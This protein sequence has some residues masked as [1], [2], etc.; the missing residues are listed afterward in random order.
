MAII[1]KDGT[2][3]QIIHRVKNTSLLFSLSFYGIIEP[4]YDANAIK[5]KLQLK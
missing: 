2:H 4:I 3:E 1:N 5:A